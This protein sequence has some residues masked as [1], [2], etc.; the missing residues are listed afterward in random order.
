MKARKWIVCFSVLVLLLFIALLQ[1][2]I[3]LSSI[4]PDG[5]GI[6]VYF[7][8]FEI[9]ERVLSSEINV[10]TSLFG[11]LSIY[12]GIALVVLILI[13]SWLFI[14]GRRAKLSVNMRE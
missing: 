11:K 1:K 9:N 5:D 8:T 6:G 13:N 7:L 2:Y 14:K 12:A 4:I 10:Y 3:S